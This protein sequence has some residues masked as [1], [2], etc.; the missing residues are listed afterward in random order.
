[1][2]CSC[3]NTKLKLSTFRK[4]SNI[5]WGKNVPQALH[6]DLPW[7]FDINFHFH[8]D[9]RDRIGMA[10]LKGY[11]YRGVPEWHLICF[12]T[13]LLKLV[14]KHAWYWVGSLCGVWTRM[15]LIGMIGICDFSAPD[16]NANILWN[17][18]ICSS[19]DKF[20]FPVCKPRELTHGPS[21]RNR[22]SE[23]AEVVIRRNLTLSQYQ[24][25]LN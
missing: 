19:V 18:W 2:I 20:H 8:T 15:E 9:Y 22:T 11:A 7:P 24:Q 21:W 1:M 16:T 4:Y 14:G 25:T 5:T 17:M 6:L 3:S 23:K 12:H 10:Q 13:W